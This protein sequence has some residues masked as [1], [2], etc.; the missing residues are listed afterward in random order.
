MIQKYYGIIFMVIILLAAGVRL[1]YINYAGSRIQI[2]PDS[3]G[4]WS[5]GNF[6]TDNLRYNYFNI[7]RMPGYSMFTSAIVSASGYGHPLFLSDD[8]FLGSWYIILAQTIIGVA[9]LFVLYDLLCAIGI[10]QT[11]RLAFTA[12]TGLNVYQFIWEHAFLNHALYITLLT[13]ILRLFAA[14]LKKPTPITGSIFVLISGYAFL[15]RPAGIGIP[16]LLLLFVW[17]RHKTKKVFVLLT[18]MLCVYSLFPLSHLIANRVLYNVKGLANSTDFVPFGRILKYNIPIDSAR[19]VQPLYDEV[20]AYR[21]LGGNVTNPWYFF[22]YYNNR[23]YA[24]PDEVT[25]F[26]RLVIRKYWFPYW[27]SIIADIPEVFFNT[28]VDG[29]L[30]HAAVPGLG[31]TFF[32]TLARIY[33]ALQWAT[34]VFFIIYPMNL[35]LYIKRKTILHTFLLA[36]GTA[37]IYQIILTPTLGGSWDFI[38]HMIPTQTYLFLFCFQGVSVIFQFIKSRFRF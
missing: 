9:G 8:F 14:L 4:Y 38:G 37:Q 11:W 30:Y 22:V 19:S 21:A 15:V 6:F 32:D 7:Y 35:W 34:V 20:V 13:I 2:E 31:K 26:N 17:L 36:I 25:R 27:K 29:V 10:A 1:A 3:Q 28:D 16:F 12:F 5:K 18:L 24:H 23:I 33:A